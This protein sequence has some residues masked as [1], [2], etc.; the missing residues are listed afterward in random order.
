MA[1]KLG[2]LEELPQDYRDA[3]SE[4]GVAPLWPMMRNVL[5]HDAPRPVT[6]PGH[7]DFEKLRPLLLKAGELTPVEKA[8]RRVLVLSDPGRG[9]GA[10]QATSSIYIGMQLLLPGETAPAHKHTPSA[11]RII[12]E[13]KGGYTVVDGEKLPMEEGDLVLTPGG[14]WHDHGHD[15]NEPVIWLDAL[16]LPLFVYLE[17]SYAIE[18][19]L[20]AQRNRPD[21]SQ[22]EY[23]ASGL[24]PARRAGT[25]IRRYPMMRYPWSR[26]EEALRE[27]A[28][29]GDGEVAELDY[30]NPE[31]GEDVLPTMGF[32]A[33]MLAEGQKVSPPRRSTSAVFHVIRGSGTTTV[34][35]E[36][37]AWKAKGTF[38]APVFA[39][40]DHQAAEESF[41]VQIHDRPLQERLRYYEERP[42]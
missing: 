26:T 25:Q 38:S 40:I 30:V 1:P 10:M 7:W 3:L 6:R 17:G 11:V 12:V 20:Q 24:A 19:E 21:A 41:L 27:M 32:T 31:T 13:G 14:E 8:E 22:V 5:P 37:I 33:M 34:D 36:T 35:G 23:R 2:T 29:Y 42:R 28:R 16:D 39:A 18:S 15:G 9:T 4:A